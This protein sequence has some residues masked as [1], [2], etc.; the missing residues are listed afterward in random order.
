MRSVAVAADRRRNGVGRRL[1]DAVIQ[2]ACELRMPAVY[3]LTTTAD[4]YFAT[5]GFEAIVRREVPASIQAS[6][7]FTSACPTSATVM[8]KWLS[9]SPHGAGIE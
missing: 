5:F 3:L 6:I 4:R 1:T 9:P 2:M 8:R 7:E